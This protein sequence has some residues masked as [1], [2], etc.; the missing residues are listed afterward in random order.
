MYI[1]VLHTFVQGPNSGLIQKSALDLIKLEL[2]VAVGYLVWVLGPELCFSLTAASTPDCW[3]I[4][5]A[6]LSLSV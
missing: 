2:Q 4:P 6:H 3:A 5:L 1:C